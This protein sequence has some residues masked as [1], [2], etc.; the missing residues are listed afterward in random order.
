MTH[1]N[2]M[3]DGW[4]R[5]RE[6]GEARQAKDGLCERLITRFLTVTKFALKTG[7]SLRR[8][9]NQDMHKFLSAP[10]CFLFNPCLLF[11]KEGLTSVGHAAAV[12]RAPF[13]FFF[14]SSAVV[15]RR[16]FLLLRM[17]LKWHGQVVLHLHLRGCAVMMKHLKPRYQLRHSLQI[18]KRIND[19]YWIYFPSLGQCK[20]HWNPGI[21][22]FLFSGSNILSVVV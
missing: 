15:C 11:C 3:R 21:D 12:P 4:G 22:L 18:R 13:F 7:P 19:D 20:L 16:T 10:R 2:G 1:G 14:Q 5:W 9:R 8:P 6:W 17:K